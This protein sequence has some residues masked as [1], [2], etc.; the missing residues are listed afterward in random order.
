ML[1][2]TA[3]EER[4]LKGINRRDHSRGPVKITGKI[5]GLWNC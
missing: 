5:C 4:V 1:N 3:R 2:K